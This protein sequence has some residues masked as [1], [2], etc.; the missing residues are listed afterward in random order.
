M[1]IFCRSVYEILCVVTCRLIII[2]TSN[3]IMKIIIDVDRN[4][5]VEN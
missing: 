1:Q 4:K 5:I 3:G 2:K